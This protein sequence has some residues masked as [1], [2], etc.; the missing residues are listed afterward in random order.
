MTDTDDLLN[1]GSDAA[2]ERGCTCPVIDN[3]HG[4]GIMG[5]G[6]QFGWWRNQDCPLHG[7]K[8]WAET[9]A[10]NAK[11]QDDDGDSR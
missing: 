11:E 6:E 2:I 4:R 1:P 5:D 8:S 7:F 9:L 10:E 3:G